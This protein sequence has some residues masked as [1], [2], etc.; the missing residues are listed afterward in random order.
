MPDISVFI[1]SYNTSG[2]LENCLSSIFSCSPQ[3]SLE[4][5]VV[6]NHSTDDTL[7]MI[8]MNFPGVNVVSLPQNMGFT[9]AINYL[10]PMG[11]GN[12]YLILHPDVVVFPETLLQLLAFFE[13]RKSAGI[14]G[15]NLQYPDGTPNAC[16]ILFPSLKNDLICFAVR[17]FR[18]LPAGNLLLGKDYNPLEWSRK[19]TSKVNWVWDACMMV[20]KAVFED[21][22]Y[23]DEDFFVWYADWDF[24]KRASD[25]GWQIYYVLPAKAVH[26]EFQSFDDSTLPSEYVRYKVDG[27]QSASVMIPDRYT[28]VRKHCSESLPGIKA[29]DLFQNTLRG[30]LILVKTLIEGPPSLSAVSRAMKAYLKNIRAICA[31]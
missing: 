27:W 14:L 26:Y 16:E 3:V 13:D 18:K 15:A 6:D 21:I 12:Y 22:G 7:Q 28:F 11:S 9:K 2:L 1:V 31:S 24:C 19:S 4:V 20:R 10:L 8:E 30:G 23:F 5:F 17:L 25:M 29:I